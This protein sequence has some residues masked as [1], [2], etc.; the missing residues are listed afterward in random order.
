MCSELSF[1]HPELLVVVVVVFCYFS[2]FLV[3]CLLNFNVFS[4]WP[5][6]LLRQLKVE[7]RWVQSLSYWITLVNVILKSQCS[8]NNLQGVQALHLITWRY[9][10]NYGLIKQ[11]FYSKLVNGSLP[12]SVRPRTVIFL[13]SKQ[14][15]CLGFPFQPFYWHGQ[16]PHVDKVF[17]IPDQR[18]LITWSCMDSNFITRRK[19]NFSSNPYSLILISCLPERK[20]CLV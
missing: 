16:Q 15:S 3:V 7:W 8:V 1:F 20:T 4:F 13:A 17:E 18:Y 11:G 9:S 19:I 5:V 14:P 10:K 2:F 6:Q 12:Q